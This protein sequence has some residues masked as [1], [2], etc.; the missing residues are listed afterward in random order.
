MQPAQGGALVLEQPEVEAVEDAGT[1]EDHR[2]HAARDIACGVVEAEKVGGKEQGTEQRRIALAM[3]RQAR[4]AAAGGEQC[5]QRN[6]CQQEAIEHRHLDGDGAKLPGDGNPG[7]APD[8]HGGKIE[9][10][11]HHI[12]GESGRDDPLWG[13]P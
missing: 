4:K 5:K 12:S 1:G 2:R 11:I 9:H 7:A 8:K 6:R 3:P 10:Q 13:E